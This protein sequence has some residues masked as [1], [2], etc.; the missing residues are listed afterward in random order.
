M[1]LIADDINSDLSDIFG[2]IRILAPE[3]WCSGQ[4]NLILPQKLGDLEK[5]EYLD[6]VRRKITELKQ[7]HDM[8]DDGLI[9]Q[10]QYLSRKA[11]IIAG[12]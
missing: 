4:R 12:R 8:L 1:K 6:Q 5:P 10:T 9:T 7:L 3:I 11:K 2:S